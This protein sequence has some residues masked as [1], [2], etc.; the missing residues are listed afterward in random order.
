MH[1][2]IPVRLSS[3]LIRL[4][5]SVAIVAIFTL[6]VIIQP[7]SAQ[8]NAPPA[9]PTGLPNTTRNNSVALSWDNT[10]NNRLTHYS[11]LRR[12]PST[13]EP[14]QFSVLNAK[15]S[16][17]NTIYIDNTMDP[18]RLPHP[19]NERQRREHQVQLHLGRHN[20]H[21]GA[22]GTYTTTETER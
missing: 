6:L 10:G 17:A 14:S 21:T 15:T 19:S 8:S 11:V 16:N 2:S 9:K 12:S 18:L 4:R 1:G 5:F 7:T 3:S 13:H 20:D 22:T